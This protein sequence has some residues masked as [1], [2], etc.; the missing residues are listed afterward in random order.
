MNITHKLIA[1]YMEQLHTAN[2]HTQSFFR[3]NISE[4]QGRIRSNI[5]YP[6]M[7]LESPEGDFSGSS[8]NNSINNKAFAFSILQKPIQGNYI[9]EDIKLDECERI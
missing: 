5:T 9:D 6:S 8:L 3:F 7:A 2:I 1:D 4:I